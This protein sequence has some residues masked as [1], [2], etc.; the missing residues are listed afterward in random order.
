[1]NDPGVVSEAPVADETSSRPAAATGAALRPVRDD[2]LLRLTWV[3]DPR[4][5]PDGTRVAFT[6]VWVDAAADEYRTA[7]SLA[8]GGD[9][10]GA[11][12]VRPLTFGPRDSQPR[13]SPDGRFIAFVRSTGGKEPA[14]LYVLPLSGG[15]ATLVCTLAK[16]AA[17]PAWSPDGRRI[18]FLSGTNLVL[19][20]PGVEKPK[21]EPG[22]VVT[23]PVFRE[24][25]EGFTDFDRMS[26]VWVVDAQGGAATPL[27]R[28]P[29]AAGAPAW[30]ADGRRILFVSDRRDEPWFGLEASV[31][32]GVSPDRDTPA[33]T[34]DLEIVVDFG[35][36]IGSFAEHADGRIAAFGYRTIEPHTYTQPRLLITE[37]ATP[38]REVRDLAP[39]V[40]D[41]FGGGINS[42]Q[43]PPRGGGA[44]P[45]AFE[46]GGETVCCAVARHGAAT[47]ARVEIASG[48]VT[49]LTPEERDLIAGTTSADGRHWAL[50]LGSPSRPGDLYR[51]DAR[52]GAITLLWAPNEAVF[53]ELALGEVEEFWY[54]SFDGTKIQAW[55]VKP[56]G[57][58]PARKYPLLLE[59]HGGPHTAYGFGFFHEFHHL[60]GAGY[61]VLYTNPRGSTTYGEGFA[62][63][64]QYRFPGDDA[65]D[66]MAGVDAVIQRGCVDPAKVGVTGGSGGGLL[67]N[68]LVTQTDRFAAAVTQRCVSDWASFF[69]S[70]DFA[71][72]VPFWFRKSPVED[73]REYLERSPVA[74]ADRITTPLMIIHSEEDWRTPIAQGEAMFRA[75][76]Q[77]RKTAVMVRFPGESHELSRSGT[78]SRRVQ[79]QRHI[80]G[81]FDRW[82]KGEPRPEYGV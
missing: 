79:N 59:I 73:P 3:A 64:I 53:A 12:S 38:R 42:D 60:A 25:D 5:S 11:A 2:D 68:W 74:F 72:F 78:P 16:G 75:L 55:L 40:D 80:R 50:T 24:N 28:G 82:I 56:P 32:Y 47:L 30:S 19:D 67:T 36:P 44:V 62:R 51:L 49:P 66:L 35:G 23:R 70:A 6:R 4:M 54:P 17:E 65:R 46:A 76:K 77:Q 15:E 37:G 45:L 52:T 63:T 81:W 13:W 26:Q 22:R 48:A 61:L 71:M 1:M 21:N 33:D 7:L 58:D 14:Q 18:A 69:Y 20:A 9:G 31:L 41:E 34:G 29:F 43:H 27:T 57:F 10:A 39:G 8:E